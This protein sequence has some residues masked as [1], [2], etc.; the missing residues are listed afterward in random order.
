MQKQGSEKSHIAN[1]VFDGVRQRALLVPVIEASVKLAR[2]S[3]LPFA[4]RLDFH[5]KQCFVSILSLIHI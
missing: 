5:L 3:A 4:K 2:Y 1:E